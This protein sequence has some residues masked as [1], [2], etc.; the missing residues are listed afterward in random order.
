[1]KY[2]IYLLNYISVF[3]NNPHYCNP[4]F[5][6]LSPFYKTKTAPQK[7]QQTIASIKISFPYIAHLSIR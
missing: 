6:I 2:I 7:A 4:F 1:M 5:H 3:Y